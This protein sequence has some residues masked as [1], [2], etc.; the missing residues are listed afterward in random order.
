MG[1]M[2]PMM[3]MMSGMMQGGFL[4]KRKVVV[5]QKMHGTCGKKRTGILMTAVQGTFGPQNHEK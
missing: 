2:M 5:W 1:M 4:V 3:G